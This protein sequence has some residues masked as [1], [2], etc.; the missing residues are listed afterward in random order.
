MGR[1]C[2]A[3][4]IILVALP[5]IFLQACN[6]P[7][8]IRADFKADP[9]A[10]TLGE[11]ASLIWDVRGA[12]TVSLDNAI[13]QVAPSGHL[14]VAPLQTTT[15]ILTAS[16]G[17]A[18]VQENVTV[19]VNPLPL[20]QQPEAI[21]TVSALDTTKLFSYMGKEVQ[22]EGDITYISSWLPDEYTGQGSTRPWTF[23]FFMKD[24]W[25]GSADNAGPGHYCPDCWRDYTS[26]F[27]LVIKPDNL[28]DFLPYF[29]WGLNQAAGQAPIIRGSAAYFQK[30]ATPGFVV[31]GPVHI[32]VRGKIQNYQSA[33]AIYLTSADQI[34]SLTGVKP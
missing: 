4:V 17:G 13:G 20:V 16:N 5:A 7:P 33:P 8:D 32:V 18:S 23:I 34:I 11:N 12:T 24:L 25:E 2:V 31:E 26:F 28:A 29:S 19:T 15:Y 27:R 6:K 14:S 21:P 3:F 9:P 10:I 30:L 1:D 22:A